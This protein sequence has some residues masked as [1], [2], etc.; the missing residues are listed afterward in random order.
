ML[1]FEKNNYWKI[2]IIY[3]TF[4]D[5]ISK[6]KK[7]Y[8]QKFKFFFVSRKNRD[9]I[10]WKNNYW[11]IFVIYLTFNE[12][13]FSKEKE[14]NQKFKFFFVSRENRDFILWRK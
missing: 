6:K 3:L 14:Y 13:Y 2:F 12:S 4:N 7:K 11:K 9:V 5:L 10:F 1:P 8:N